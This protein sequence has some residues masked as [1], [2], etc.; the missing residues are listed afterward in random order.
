MLELAVS[1][2]RTRGSIP[3]MVV[4]EVMR[5]GRTRSTVPWT[6]AARRAM[7]RS[8]RT[9][10]TW[11]TSRIALLTTMPPHHDHADPR[12]PGEVGVGEE[13]DHE[14]AISAMGTASSTHR[15]S[16]SD[17]KSAAVTIST[18]KIETPSTSRIWDFSSVDHRQRSAFF[19]V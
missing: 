11:S 7:P 9:L 17:S 4:V 15:G 12:L 3:R 10:P 1:L 18:K 6:I 8:R 5:I 14:D 2:K 13:E 19:T 16:R